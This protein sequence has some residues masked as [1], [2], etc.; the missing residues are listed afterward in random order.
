MRSREADKPTPQFTVDACG[1]DGWA[2]QKHDRQLS[3]LYFTGQSDQLMA[4][5]SPKL[6]TKISF[7]NEYDT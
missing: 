1:R 5:N 6:S 7:V 4:G 3:F 2:E